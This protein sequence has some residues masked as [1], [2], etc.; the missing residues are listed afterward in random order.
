V[1]FLIAE[2]TRVEALTEKNV[3]S[4]GMSD[5]GQTCSGT[6]L[7]PHEVCLYEIEDL[8]CDEVSWTV[9]QETEKV[10]EPESPGPPDRFWQ[11]LTLISP[12]YGKIMG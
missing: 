7:D 2:A 12:R 5:N 9:D 1:D 10:V 11:E 3:S 6:C 4:V 8:T